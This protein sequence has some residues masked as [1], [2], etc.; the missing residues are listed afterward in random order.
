MKHTFRL[1]R[2]IHLFDI[3]EVVLP[4]ER[5]CPGLHATK[6]LVLDITVECRCLQ[7]RNKVIHEFSGGYL[8]KKVISTVLDTDIGQ[9]DMG[10]PDVKNDSKKT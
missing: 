8:Y 9:L 6:N 2:L 1:Q 4:F 7:Y 10:M 3:T 5:N